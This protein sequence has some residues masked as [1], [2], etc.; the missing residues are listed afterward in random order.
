MFALSTQF[1]TAA[2]GTAVLVAS[3]LVTYAWL[4]SLYR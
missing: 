4:R 3:L 2:A 1:P